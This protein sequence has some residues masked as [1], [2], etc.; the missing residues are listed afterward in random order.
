[1]AM[2]GEVEF[3]GSGA[4]AAGP[5]PPAPASASAS[6]PASAPAS[7]SAPVSASVSADVLA[8]LPAELRDVMQREIERQVAD[9]VRERLEPQQRLFELAQEGGRVGVF[10]IDMRNG[11]STGSRMWARLLGQA[12]GTT[13]VGRE[14]WTRML[15]PEDRERVLKAVAR[16]VALGGDTAL[17]YRI[18]LP[19]GSER[20]LSSRNLIEQ[21]EL[22][23]SLRAYGTLHDITERK[24]LEAQILYNASHDS[25]TGLANRR[26]FMEELGNA[27]EE[28]HG[29][30]DRVAVALFDLDDLK[31]ANDRH[32]HE[33]GDRLLQAS[34]DR[35]GAVAGN[36]GV[37]A[38][39]GG[40]EFALLLKG[41]NALQLRELAEQ[42]LRDIRQPVAFGSL[43]LQ[44]GASA[45]GAVDRC[46]PTSSP[47]FLLRRA[48]IALYA[49]KRTARGEYREAPTG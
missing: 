7:V 33:A 41:R 14:Q 8:Q 17:D 9:R 48:D 25:L 35:L 11:Y 37:A 45:G 4:A 40:D 21:D 29:T 13:H 32:G 3:D 42:S 34:A 23:R 44:S 10:E 27:F 19:D 46:L 6:V 30:D 28:L 2:R 26:R 24:L 16:A 15:H 12:E 18:R 38:R 43:V 49:A 39:L 20:W 47:K 36:R 5:A 22:G 31:P 1:M